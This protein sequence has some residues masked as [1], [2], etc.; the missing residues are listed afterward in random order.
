MLYTA[1][2]SLYIY[3]DSVVS[4]VLWGSMEK[5]YFLFYVLSTTL[6]ELYLG[7]CFVNCPNA[8]WETECPQTIHNL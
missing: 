3:K 8:V 5:V 6:G 4:V 2:G 1:V 7:M